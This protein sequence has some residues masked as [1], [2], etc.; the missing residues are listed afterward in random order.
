FFFIIISFKTNFRFKEF[1]KFSFK[2]L[3]E[4]AIIGG[5]L[6]F[7]LFF[8]GL[9]LTTSARA[10]FIYKEIILFDNFFFKRRLTRTQGFAGMLISIGLPF[11]LA[12]EISPGELWTNPE[13]G[14]FL[15]I[16]AVLLWGLEKY[17]SN[18]EM[19]K[20]EHNFFISFSKMFFG[21][22]ILLSSI[23]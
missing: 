3:L 17:I 15:V 9:K 18:K 19:I 11:I 14:D 22:A 10:V 21:G 7:F 4:I 20:E 8:L 12:D 1:K 13:L 2:Y 16:V 6:A 5:S 23:I